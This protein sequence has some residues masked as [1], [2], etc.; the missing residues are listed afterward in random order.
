MADMLRVGSPRYTARALKR[1]AL[2]ACEKPS[3]GEWRKMETSLEALQ[4]EDKSKELRRNADMYVQPI[5]G[6]CQARAS[7][8]HAF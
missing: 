4:S 5:Y 6:C 8:A 3:E 1:R 7:Y 2:Y